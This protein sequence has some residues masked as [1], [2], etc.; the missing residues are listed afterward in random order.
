LLD[1]ETMDEVRDM[2]KVLAP[3]FAHYDTNGDK[4]IEF[5]EFQMILRDLNETLE[6]ESQK[7]LFNN[8]DIDSSGAI[9]FEEFAACLMTFALDGSNDEGRQGP[10][11][12]ACPSA[13]VSL[14]PKNDVE[15]GD[16]DEDEGEEKEDVPEDLADLAPEEQQRRIKFRAFTKMFAG[17]VLCLIFSDPMVDLLSEFGTRIGVRPFYISFIFA[18]LASNASE[19]VSAYTYAKKRTIKSMTTS[20]STLEGA[21]IMNNTFC[22]GIF[23]ALVYCKNLAWEF[24]AETVSIIAIQ[25]MLG[26]SVIFRRQQKLMDGLI[27]LS[28]YPMAMGIVAVLEALGWD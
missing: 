15:Q 11:F 25:L 27:V 20:L 17:T 10:K 5:D 18:P 19:F 7:K 3:F 22:L 13:Y 14:N 12:V 16:D 28:Y 24:T 8:A 1:T 26:F 4:Q 6:K 9:S 2:C 23:L 21:A